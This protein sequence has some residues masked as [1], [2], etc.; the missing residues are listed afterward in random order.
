MSKRCLALLFLSFFIFDTNTAAQDDKNVARKFD[1]FGDVYVT[2]IKARADN[3]AIDLQNN[4]TA[5]GFIVVLSLASR[6]S[7]NKF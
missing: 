3:F 5:K 7:G 2:D 6:S 4:P 1:E